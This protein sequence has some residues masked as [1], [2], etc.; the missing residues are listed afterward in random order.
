MFAFPFIFVLG[1]DFDWSRSYFRFLILIGGYSKNENQTV[2]ST[3][4]LSHAF[5]LPPFLVCVYWAL[6]LL[7]WLEECPSFLVSMINGDRGLWYDLIVM[8]FNR[9]GGNSFQCINVGD[10]ARSL[11]G[12]CGNVYMNPMSNH[13]NLFICESKLAI[14]LFWMKSNMDENKEL[15]I[16]FKLSKRKSIKNIGKRKKAIGK[17]LTFSYHHLILESITWWNENVQLPRVL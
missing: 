4:S 17:E 2:Y 10:P 14:T 7:V 12:A 1:F 9:E 5:F 3:L 15:Y 11:L 6:V 16:F 13:L 8:S